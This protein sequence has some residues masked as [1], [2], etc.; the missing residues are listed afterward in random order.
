[1]NRG[2]DAEVGAGAPERPEQV[3]VL[4]AA[5]GADLAVGGDD[6]DLLEVVDRPAEAARQVAEAAAERQA[7]DADL[8]DEAEHGRQPVLLRLPVDVAAAGSPGPTC[9]ASRSGSTVTLA[10]PRHVE[11]QAAVG[12]RGAGDVVAAAPDAEQQAVLAR[13]ADGRGDVAGRCGWTTSAGLVAIMPF[14]TARRRPSPR[15]PPGGASRRGAR[16]VVELARRQRGAAVASRDVDGAPPHAALPV[17]AVPRGRSKR[18][19]ERL[20]RVRPAGRRRSPR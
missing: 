19:H 20:R 9:A 2:D 8:G 11:R 1:M 16:Q 13:E 6:L 5:G 17:A 4:V 12:E 3:G 10:H 15:R 7:G 14:Q 18:A